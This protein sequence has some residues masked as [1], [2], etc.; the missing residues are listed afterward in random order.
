MSFWSRIS[1]VGAVKDFA[2]EW[3]QPTG[4]RWVA[5]GI[6]IATTSTIMIVFLPAN[7]RIDPPRP[8]IF[9]ITT[10]APDRTHEE[11]IASNIAYQKRK[12]E[13]QDLYDQRAELRKDM[14]RQL[15]RASGL[16]VDAMEAEIEQ[17]R[18]A[19][20]ALAE[21]AALEAAALETAATKTAAVETVQEP[22][23]E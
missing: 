3:K 20:E 1:P 15:G 8:E 14:Y 18:A 13:I 9:Y 5:M 11:I 17:D 10:W 22:R 21:T 23:A 12:D 19:D 4:H 6:A 16:D 7:Q 2:D